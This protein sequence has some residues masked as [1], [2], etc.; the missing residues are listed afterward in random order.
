MDGDSLGQLPKRPNGTDC[1]SVG[2]RLRRFESSTAHRRPS[3]W[4][5]PSDQR[6]ARFVARSLREARSRVHAKGIWRH[7]S[8]GYC[9]PQERRDSRPSSSGAEHN[10]GKVGV[11][12]SIPI[13]GSNSPATLATP[14]L[15]DGAP[16]GTL[17]CL[18]RVGAIAPA[19]VAGMTRWPTC[20]GV[21][22]PLD[23]ASMSAPRLVWRS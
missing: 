11:M 17:L 6:C 2:L 16:G 20:F 8:S 21:T 18:A 10:L 4:F 14:R 13:S 5:S 19:S 12:G 23:G 1:K 3:G 7:P 15:E 22:H 9:R